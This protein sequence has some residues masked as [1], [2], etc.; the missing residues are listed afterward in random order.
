MAD[1]LPYLGV[2]TCYT[3]EDAAGRTVVLED[4]TGLTSQQAQKYLK[5]QGLTCQ[6]IG[7]EDAVTAQIP[8]AGQAVPGDSQVI[9]YFG[10]APEQKTVTVPDF[11]GMTRQQA[12]DAAGAI[13]L[14]ILPKGNLDVAPEIKVTSQSVPKDSQVG[15]GTV[16][17][18][19]FTDTKAA[20]G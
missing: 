1:I 6:L 10:E 15:V 14:Y 16:I 17:E 18:L 5:E 2:K 20:D 4:M 3:E 12:S 7:V 11:T 13:G 19:Q 8:A 9:L